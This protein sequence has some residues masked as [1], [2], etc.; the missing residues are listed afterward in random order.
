MD[1]GPIKKNLYIAFFRHVMDEDSEDGEVN[2]IATNFTEAVKKAETEGA[3]VSTGE[4]D[5]VE[6]YRIELLAKI[7]VE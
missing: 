4:K 6:M 5:P 3:R 2:V 7:D 1:A